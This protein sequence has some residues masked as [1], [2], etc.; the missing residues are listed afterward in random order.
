MSDEVDRQDDSPPTAFS[1]RYARWGALGVHERDR[2]VVGSRREIARAFD[3]MLRRMMPGDVAS[4]A[5]QHEIYPQDAVASC[6][7]SAC[8][9]VRSDGEAVCNLPDGHSGCHVG[10]VGLLGVQW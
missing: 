3:E 7:D 1:L 6:G 5:V 8:G 10:G 2:V 9:A 4:I